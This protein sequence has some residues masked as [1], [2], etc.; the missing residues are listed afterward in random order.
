MSARQ[1]RRQGLY[2]GFD[3]RPCLDCGRD[4]YPNSKHN[5]YCYI[6]YHRINRRTKGEEIAGSNDR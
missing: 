2:A 3:L 6:C 1:E 4:F 5:R